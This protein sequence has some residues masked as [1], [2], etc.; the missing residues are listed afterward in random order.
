MPRKPVDGV[1]QAIGFRSSAR[2]KV[3]ARK[4]AAGAPPE[5]ARQRATPGP[6]PASLSRRSSLRNPAARGEPDE[7]LDEAARN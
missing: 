4:R 5:V 1:E 3:F 2:S 7:G 6:L